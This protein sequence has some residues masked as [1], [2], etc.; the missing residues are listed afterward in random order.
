MTTK[1]HNFTVLLA[2]IQNAGAPIA[3]GYVTFSV[4]GTTTAK[5]AYEDRDKS[6]AI[7]K[8][9]LD[10]N[11]RAE[12]FG[13]GIYRLRFYIGDPDAAPPN[14]GVE[15]SALE[16]EAYKCT[17]V[18]GNSRT[19]ATDTVGN[20]D[21]GLVLGNTASGNVQYTLPDAALVSGTV[22]VGKI[23]PANTF[24]IACASGQTINGASTLALTAQY[25]AILAYSNGTNWYAARDTLAGLGVSAFALTLLDAPDG[26]TFLDTLIASATAAKARGD[27][28]FAS[29]VPPVPGG[30][31]TNLTGEPVPANTAAANNI[32]YV[33]YLHSTIILD[34]GS[35]VLTDYTISGMAQGLADDT[36]S[37]AAGAA[38]KNY[39][40][41]AWVDAGTLRCTRGPLWDSLTVRGTGVGKTELIR[42]SI[43]QWVNR[44]DIT[45]GP[46]A[47]KGLYV[48]TINTNPSG[49]TVSQTR[50]GAS[51]FGYWGVWN[52]F[53]RVPIDIFIWD[54]T[55][56]HTYTTATVR[57]WQASV[58]Y[59]FSFVRGMNE[60]AVEADAFA[61]ALNTNTGVGVIAGVGLDATNAF[62]GTVGGFTTAIANG[63]METKGHYI[64]QPGLGK[65]YIAWLQYSAATGTTTWNGDGGGVLNLSGLT[66]RLLA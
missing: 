38:D 18:Y 19:I 3:T 61:T 40:M 16:I 22:Q 37:P 34:N 55:D 25:D 50:G 10:S 53:N 17:A 65:H 31:L 28:E 14:Q 36:K 60:D 20:V 45:N 15:V 26:E 41:F 46:G 9:A 35:G 11:G 47:G 30:R 24:T 62:S 2:G 13:D 64:G 51:A 57:Q 27:I 49:A 21:D 59:Q 43:G 63:R 54:T 44:Y 42:N 48:G 58:N 7:T 33:P 1:A 6:V 56:T 23:A 29:H 66:G 8:K 4:P 32:Y 52:M 12:V 39:D 5:T